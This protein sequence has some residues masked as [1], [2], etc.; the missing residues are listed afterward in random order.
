MTLGR[1]GGDR[2]GAFWTAN[3]DLPRGPGHV[4]YDKLN[5]VLAKAGFDRTLE[6]LCAPYYATSGRASI[7][8]GVYFRMLMIGY[9]EGKG[10][11]PNAFFANNKGHF[12]LLVEM[13]GIF[14]RSDLAAEGAVSA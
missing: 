10:F 1:R 12:P 6:E 8:P 11:V 3:Q 4:F 13:D 14:I 9:L 2:Q 7:P 5:A